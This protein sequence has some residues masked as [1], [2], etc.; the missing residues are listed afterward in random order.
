MRQPIK[1]LSPKLRKYFTEDR[2]RSH[3]PF[4]SEC[5]STIRLLKKKKKYIKKETKC[6]NYIRLY[7]WTNTSNLT[8]R[9]VACI[10]RRE[11]AGIIHVLSALFVV[12]LF[13]SFFSNYCAAL[14]NFLK[15]E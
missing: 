7:L 12:C 15:L 1:H 9:S 10:F 3:P 6:I 2:T 8:Q 4:K 5:C 14:H 13:D 11:R